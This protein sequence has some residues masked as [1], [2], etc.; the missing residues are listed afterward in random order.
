MDGFTWMKAQISAAFG[1]QTFSKKKSGSG[2]LAVLSLRTVPVK[3]AGTATLCHPR[4]MH[5]INQYKRT[6]PARQCTS[7]RRA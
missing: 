7:M 4:K 6:A 2:S 3:P 5:S 1:A